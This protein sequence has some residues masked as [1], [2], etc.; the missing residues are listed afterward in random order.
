MKRVCQVIGLKPECYEK[1]KNLHD[2]IWPHIVERLRERNI[3]NYTIFYLDGKLTAYFE[4][5]GNDFE[6]DMAIQE[7][8]IE[9]QWQEQCIA[10]Q[11]SADGADTIRWLPQEVLFHMD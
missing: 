5:V 4:Y 2:H 1:Y 9:R 8:D 6:A 11:S 10:M 7:D 3:R